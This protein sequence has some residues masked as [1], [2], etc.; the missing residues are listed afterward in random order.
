MHM[1][2]HAFLSKVKGFLKIIDKAIAFG[3][4]NIFAT[5]FFPLTRD[6]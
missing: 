3:F 5:V 6:R 4:S 1:N 2:Y